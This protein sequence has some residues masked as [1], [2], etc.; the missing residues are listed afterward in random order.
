MLR[1]SRSRIKSRLD[2]VI[3]LS[4]APSLVCVRECNIYKE[5]CIVVYYE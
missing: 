3:A 2:S 5:Q 4:L 1:N